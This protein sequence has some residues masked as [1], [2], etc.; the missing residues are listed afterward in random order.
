M[1]ACRLLVVALLP[2]AAVAARAQEALPS[3]EAF[4]P[5]SGRTWLSEC[6]FEADRYVTCKHAARPVLEAVSNPGDGTPGEALQ[7][8]MRDLFVAKGCAFDASADSFRVNGIFLSFD[9]NAAGKIRCRGEPSKLSFG[10][11]VIALADTIYFLSGD[12]PQ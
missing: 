9:S 8:F 5:G 6:A 7:A 10:P 4:E 12:P 2:L 1:R 3:K 11:G